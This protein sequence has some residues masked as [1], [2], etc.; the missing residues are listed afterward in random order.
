MAVE[1]IRGSAC[2][3][4]FYPQGGLKVGELGDPAIGISQELT[5]LDLEAVVDEENNRVYADLMEVDTIQL[6]EGIDTVCQLVFT[7]DETEDVLRFPEHKLTVS[8]SLFGEFYES[9]DL[10]EEGE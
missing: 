6:V 8:P 3:I 10:E 5:F 4:C 2:R 1:I 9:E 7:D